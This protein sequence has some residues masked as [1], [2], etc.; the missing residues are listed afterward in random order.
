MR[1]KPTDDGIVDRISDGLISGLSIRKVCAPD[2]MPS[3][4][5]VYLEMAK[6]EDFRNAIAHARDLQQDAMVDETVDMADDATVEDWQLVKMQIWARQW[7]ASKLAPKRYGDR[8][9]LSGDA[10]APL[11]GGLAESIL[12]ARARIGK[13]GD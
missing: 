10:D 8:Q 13:D 1:P 5:V 6:N 4:S 9:I 3:V 7:R 12:A 11:L 2:D